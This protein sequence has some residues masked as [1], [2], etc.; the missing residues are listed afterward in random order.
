MK[1]LFRIIF[2]HS[3]SYQ[4]NSQIAKVGS[5]AKASFILWLF[6]AAFGLGG[7]Q[8]RISVPS[9]LPDN[10]IVFQYYP[11]EAYRESK[12]L[13]FVSADGKDFEERELI[14]ESGGIPTW[15][16]NGKWIVYRWGIPPTT[17]RSAA[18]IAVG[19]LHICKENELWGT[20]RPHPVPNRENLVISAVR[21]VEPLRR[22]VTIDPLLCEVVET[23]YD[24]GYSESALAYPALSSKGL[25]AVGVPDH[26]GYYTRILV[27][28]IETGEEVEMG[29]GV[30]MAWSPD[31]E[32]LAYTTYQGIM[33]ARSDGSKKRLVLSEGFARQDLPIPIA[34][35]VWSFWPPY[36]AWS[37]D[38]KWLV[39][40]LWDGRQ[41]N[42][43]KLNVQTEEKQL[44][45]RNGVYPHWRWPSDLYAQTP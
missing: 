20:G 41:F 36:P 44:V 40:H 26:R 42:I 34:G 35:D 5:H 39:F 24:F 2:R 27:I 30:G 23:V 16:S 19:G 9:P 37:P 31:G 33:V 17:G 1:K 8:D 18:Y 32:W 3:Q 43:Y 12:L 45:Y 29:Y 13:G 11:V 22:I 14:E 6:V 10:E 38:G 25:L 21:G 7:C 28:D 15:S 4:Q